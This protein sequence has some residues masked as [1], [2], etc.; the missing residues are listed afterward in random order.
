MRPVFLT[1]LCVTL[2]GCGSRTTQPPVAESEER[3]ETKALEA[4]RAVGYDGKQIRKT[5]DNAIRKTEERH[6]ELET[7]T[8]P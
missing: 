4:A 8:G 3:P 5:V 1:I 7:V 6:K 2:W